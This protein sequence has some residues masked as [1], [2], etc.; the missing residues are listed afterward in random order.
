MYTSDTYA[1]CSAYAFSVCHVV[2]DVFCAF[3]SGILLYIDLEPD[4]KITQQKI[5]IHKIKQC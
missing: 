3:R 5:S 4:N 2:C 1:S